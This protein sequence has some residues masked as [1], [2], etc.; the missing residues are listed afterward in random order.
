MSDKFVI[1]EGATVSFEL[2]GVGSIDTIK[3]VQAHIDVTVERDSI[4]I[5]DS[6]LF[7]TDSINPVEKLSD[8]EFEINIW[9]QDAYIV[10]N[11]C[12]YESVGDID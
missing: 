4:L 6:T 2:H 1:P 12:F 10:E 3:K 7:C 8:T 11:D 5:I 9:L